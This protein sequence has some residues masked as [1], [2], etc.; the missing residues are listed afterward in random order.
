[1]AN[2]NIKLARELQNNSFIQTLYKDTLKRMLSLNL[3][4]LTN[5]ELDE[6]IDY[7][8]NKRYKPVE[9]KVY[10]NYTE[11]TVTNTL[12]ELTDYIYSREPIQ[13]AWG[14]LFKKHGVTP[15]PLTKLI[16]MFMLNRDKEKKIMFQYPKGSEEF[17]EHNLLQL[18]AKVDTNAIYGVNLLSV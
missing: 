5:K 7:S 16:H 13:T 17:E 12:A 2:A 9:S 8:M 4:S 6:A 15:N 14:V 18:L 1:M 11:V 10:N 3:P